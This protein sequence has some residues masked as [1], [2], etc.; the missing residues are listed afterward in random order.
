VLEIGGKKKQYIP[1]LNSHVNGV[2][3]TYRE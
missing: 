3:Q 1:L 2:E